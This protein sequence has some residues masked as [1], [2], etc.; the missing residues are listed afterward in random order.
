MSNA[1]FHAN[2]VRQVFQGVLEDVAIARIAAAAIAE[3]EHGRRLRVMN[4]T[5]MLPGMSD[6]V[7]GE[8]AGVVADAQVDVPVVAAHVVQSVRMDDSLGVG[9]EVVIECMDD[10]LGVGVPFAEKVAEVFLLFGVDAEDGIAGSLV[11]G[12]KTSNFQKLTIAVGMLFEGAFFEGFASSHPVFNQQLDD[13]GHADPESALGQ[14]GCDA[15]ERKIGPQNAVAHRVASREWPYNLQ[16]G[17]IQLGEQAQA[18][19]SSAPFFR[20]WPGASDEPS[21]N[22]QRP[23]R[24]VFGSQSKTAARYCKPPCP[25]LMASAAA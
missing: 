20:D 2:S 18:G 16:E 12:T 22:S 3:Q 15:A 1:Y 25:S 7:A 11:F 19:F 5:I 13:N 21:C 14:I 6:A 23:R 4:Q 8:F 10:F 24:M 9:R 17:G